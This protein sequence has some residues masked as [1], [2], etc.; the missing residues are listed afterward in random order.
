MI[1]ASQVKEFLRDK[2][3]AEAA[4][5]APATTYSDEDR[6]SFTATM[7]TMAAGNPAMDNTTLFDPQDFVE[8]AKA[9]IVFGGNSYFGADPYSRGGGNGEP[10]GAIGNFYLNE[11]ILNR[12]L[13]NV[14]LISGFLESK[15]FKADSPFVGFSQKVKALE[16][17][18]GFRGKNTLVLNKKFGSWISLITVITDA[19]LEPD[20]PVEG[21]CGKC[22][23]CVE[24]CPTGALSSPYVYQVDKCIIYYLCHLKKEIPVGVREKIGVRTANCTVCSDVCPRNKNLLINEADKLPDDVI[25]PKLIPMMNMT[26]DE[27][28]ER[29]GSQMFGFIMGGRTYLR[30]N[31]AVALGNSGSTKAV[32]CLETAARDEDPLVR[33]HAEWA[34]EK[35]KECSD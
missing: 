30:R 22:N 16:A 31:I 35:I 5:I 9:V 19:P 13:Q 4:G 32:P 26:E 23:R 12:S 3:G 10:R 11:K 7:E 20:Q 28:E 21:D 33:S 6:K 15:G 27:Y 1:T 14:S 8:G 29:Y 25:Y 2:C 17:G 34:L 24:A 18:I